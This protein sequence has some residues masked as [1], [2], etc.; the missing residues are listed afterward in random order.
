MQYTNS[1]PVVCSTE[2]LYHVIYSWLQEFVEAAL[3]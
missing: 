1:T 3:Y 2:I